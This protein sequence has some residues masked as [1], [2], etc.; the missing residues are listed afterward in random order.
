MLTKVTSFSSA[1]GS[2][3]GSASGQGDL[4]SSVMHRSGAASNEQICMALERTYSLSGVNTEMY[5]LPE[6]VI[7]MVRSVGLSS[8]PFST[9][10][11]M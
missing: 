4:N 3:Y 10:T 7:L 11:A 9:A 5:A 8:Q 6:S 2:S 1:P